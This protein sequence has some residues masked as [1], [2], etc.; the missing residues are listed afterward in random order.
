MKSQH[1]LAILV[2][3]FIWTACSSTPPIEEYTLARSAIQAAKIHE[4]QRFAPAFWHEAEEFYR[5]GEEAFK[6]ESYK[7]AR[8]DFDNARKAAERAENVA[9]LQRFKNGDSP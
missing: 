6:S 4:A 5:H 2:G 3:A 9:R 8:D 1:V 7:V